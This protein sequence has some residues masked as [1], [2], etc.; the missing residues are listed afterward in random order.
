MSYTPRGNKVIYTVDD[1]CDNVEHW[2]RDK[3]KKS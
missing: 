3:G 2:F 1:P